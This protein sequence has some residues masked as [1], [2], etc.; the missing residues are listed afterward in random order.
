MTDTLGVH[1]TAAD[2]AEAIRIAV[3]ERL[4]ARANILPGHTAIR[5]WQGAVEEAKEAALVLK[6]T[7]FRFDVLSA[8][9][10]ALSSYTTP[11]IVALPA[12]TG[13]GDFLAWVRDQARDAGDTGG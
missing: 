12:A 1:V 5:S 2:R 13:D 9:F 11:C 3:E 8:R 7:A 4:A 6:T 10:R